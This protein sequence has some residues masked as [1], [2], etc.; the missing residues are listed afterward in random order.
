MYSDG[1]S[2]PSTGLRNDS[3]PQ[4]DRSSDRPAL[5][6][7]P[8]T[9]APSGSD[10]PSAKQRGPSTRR[11]RFSLKEEA[12]LETLRA[13]TPF[14]FGAS[15]K[16]PTSKRLEERGD[17]IAR[18]GALGAASGSAPRPG[19][20]RF[21]GSAPDL[22]AEDDDESGGESGKAHAQGTDGHHD[23]ME[24]GGFKLRR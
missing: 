10:Q 21:A 18:L 19:G 12:A 3:Q 20:L 5:N 17:V 13:S 22:D 16:A 6:F 11:L 23:G 24:S 14:D 1:E 2:E 4:V 9:A 8:L 7:R 15:F